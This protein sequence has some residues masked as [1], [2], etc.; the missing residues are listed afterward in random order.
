MLVQGYEKMSVNPAIPDRQEYADGTVG[1]ID[2]HYSRTAKKLVIYPSLTENIQCDVC[3]VGGGLAGLVTALELARA[4][5]DTVLLESRRLAW[6]ASGRNGGFVSPGFAE[7]VFAIEQR[8]G[9]AHAQALYRLSVEGV[10]YVRNLI[11]S[12]GD[13]GIIGGHGWLKM[14]RHNDPA[15]LERQAERMVRD[16]GAAYNFLEKQALAE[17]VSSPVYQAG[18]LDMMP[19]HIQPLDFAALVARNA[20][21]CGAGLHENSSVLSI[22]RNGSKWHVKTKEGMVAADQIVL[23]TSVYGGPSRRLN[24]AMQPVSTYVVTAQC[25][26]EIL[27]Q[28]IRFTGCLGDT[29]RA[30]DYYRL[31]GEGNRQRLLWGGRITTR[32]SVPRH[33]AEMLRRDIEKVYPQLKGLKIDSAWAGLMGYAVHKMPI[34]GKIGNGLWSATGFGGHGLNTTAM[35]GQL[36]ASAIAGNDDRYRLFQP[37]GIVW[38]GGKIG[39]IATQCEYL[40]LR[41]L[42]RFGEARARLHNAQK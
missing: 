17:H 9:L 28:A 3:I 35:A 5:I 37:Y 33:L 42:D 2:S 10:A 40:R 26:P 21:S 1:H 39:R 31:V 18:M 4:G 19:F 38:A 13:S 12:S 36:I 23:A 22:A 16:Y 25:P 14:I 20:Q 29:R 41:L 8:L 27:H 24:G 15:G 34:I 30:G 32:T 7:S 6:G 11:N